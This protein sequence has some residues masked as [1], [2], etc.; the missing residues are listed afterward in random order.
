M[1]LPCQQ[2]GL[3]QSS[4]WD[5]SSIVSGC[6]CRSSAR[7]RWKSF[8]LF[9]S[10]L[11]LLFFSLQL[12]LFIP[13]DNKYARIPETKF[14]YRNTAIESA[15]EN[16]VRPLPRCLRITLRFRNSR[17]PVVFYVKHVHKDNLNYSTE[18]NSLV[19]PLTPER[20]FLWPWLI[21]SRV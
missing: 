2:A 19:E 1:R 5:F 9:L 21:I 3:P 7:R 11:L 15:S 8:S 17:R 13:L 12:L 18:T 20:P 16:G 6:G 10:L 4:M 14:T